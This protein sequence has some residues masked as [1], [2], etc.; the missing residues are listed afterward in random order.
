MK[1]F[2]FIATLSMLSLVS[3]AQNSPRPLRQL[4]SIKNQPPRLPFFHKEP[5]F[6]LKPFTTPGLSLSNSPKL[7]AGGPDSD[8]AKELPM[9]QK[10]SMRVVKPDSTI[11]YSML[12]AK[13][14]STIRYH[15]QIKKP[16]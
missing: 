13:P 12:T 14:D 4:P 5:Y 8:S 11:H 3:Y 16:K 7:Y 9:R 15:L 1:T 10:A 6:H 2:I